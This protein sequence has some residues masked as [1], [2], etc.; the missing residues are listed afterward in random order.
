MKEEAH[1]EDTPRKSVTEKTDSLCKFT[2]LYG[3]EAADTH[4]GIPWTRGAE[5]TDSRGS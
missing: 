4:W 1:G 2:A 3:P 5:T